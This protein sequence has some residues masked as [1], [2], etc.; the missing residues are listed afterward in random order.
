MKKAAVR[1][2]A[3]GGLMGWLCWALPAQVLLAQV[4]LSNTGPDLSPVRAGTLPLKWDT[5]GPR[6]SQMPEWQIHEY[7]PDLYFLRQSGCT[8][9]EKPFVFL[10]FG[11]ERALLLDTGSRRGNL[12]PALQL[13]MHRWLSAN[14]RDHIPL[15]VAHTH[16]HS[17]HVAGD[18]QLQALGDPDIPITYVAPTVD[19]TK[20]FYG[21]ANWPED[22]GKVDLG[23][24]TLDVLAI[25]GHDIVSIAVYD[26]QTAILFTGDSVYPGRLY[27]RDFAAFEKSNER[28]LRF[29]EG[30][31][32]A[33]LLGNHIEEQRTP[34]LDYPVR[35][36]YQPD[37]HEWA[38][39][40]GTLFE[41]Q[42]GLA[43]MHGKPQRVAFR[44]FTLWPSEP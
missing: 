43:A 15:I 19:A 9:F 28:M 44:D 13:V 1:A 16:S 6:C 26:R 24:R 27:I 39:S 33:H 14:H 30:K 31:P 40:R 2:L 37:E 29:T 12:A 35:T 22:V 18:A 42:A 34:Y 41:I 8:D 5:G 20:K 38:L 10:L 4:L 21:I 36:E 32:V 17:D 25:P 3:G 23:N 11:G 7:N